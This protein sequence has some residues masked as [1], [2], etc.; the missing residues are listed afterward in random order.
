MNSTFQ[1]ASHRAAG[2][3]R[4]SGDDAADM[5]GKVSAMASNAADTVRKTLRDTADVAGATMEKVGAR[6]DEMTDMAV[7]KGSELQSALVEE[8]KGNPLMAIGIAFGAGFILA[9]LSRAM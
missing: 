7:K 4:K 2:E 5:A 9:Q 8:I 1:D 6:T 3:V